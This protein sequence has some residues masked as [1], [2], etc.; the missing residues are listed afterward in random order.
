MVNEHDGS[1]MPANVYDKATYK[2]HPSFGPKETQ[3]EH[4][5][6]SWLSQVRVVSN[7]T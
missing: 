5:S 3:G 1:M 6:S 2:L 7:E 4:D